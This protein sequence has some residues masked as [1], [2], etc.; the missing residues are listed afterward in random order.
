V[1]IRGD[2]SCGSQDFINLPI[3]RLMVED[4]SPYDE[5]ITGVISDD[6]SISIP[7]LKPVAAF[8]LVLEEELAKVIV[9]YSGKLLITLPLGQ[10]IKDLQSFSEK[11]TLVREVKS[12]ANSKKVEKA[13]VET[14]RKILVL[15]GKT[16]AVDTCFVKL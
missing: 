10:Y 7:Y 16:S 14:L 2:V 9:Q 6:Y 4:F 15:L 1:T 3:V 12:I 13:D 8:R 5:E 11:K